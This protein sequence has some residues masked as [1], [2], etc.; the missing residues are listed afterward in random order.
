MEAVQLSGTAID[1]G[2]QAN[3]PTRSKPT[4]LAQPRAL[5]WASNAAP[6]GTFS[7]GPVQRLGLAADEVALATSN[8]CAGRLAA[9]DLRHIRR[10]AAC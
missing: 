5:A 7:G 10:N 3:T 4:L 1:G 8:E 6:P 2:L 9:L